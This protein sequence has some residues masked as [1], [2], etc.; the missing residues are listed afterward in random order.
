[1][2]STLRITA[3]TS[4]AGFMLLAAQ[5]RRGACRNGLPARSGRRSLG[6]PRAGAALGAHALEDPLAPVLLQPR[7]HALDLAQDLLGH[8]L[9]LLARGVLDP[10]PADRLG[11]LHGHAGKLQPLPV[12]NL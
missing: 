6:S 1:M 2:R 4:S 11:V 8:R 9:L 3:P 12:A 7:V 10:L 5:L